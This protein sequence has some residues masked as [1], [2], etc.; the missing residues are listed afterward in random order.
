MNN[1]HESQLKALAEENEQLKGDAMRCALSRNNLRAEKV[2]LQSKN[3]AL[4]QE[5]EGLEGEIE[6]L[7]ETC[8][9]KD[10]LLAERGGH[11]ERFEKLKKE[12]QRYEALANEK[13]CEFMKENER[14]LKSEIECL[15]K[16]AETQESLNDAKAEIKRLKDKHN[17]LLLR[18]APA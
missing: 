5:K 15:K 13:Y 8:V 17:T 11:K 18:L 4:R 12:K 1:T 14:L 10:I 7:K 16:R 3:R 9:P 2:E 6:E